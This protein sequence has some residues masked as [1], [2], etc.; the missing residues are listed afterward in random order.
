MAEVRVINPIVSTETRELRV[1]AY[2]RVSSDSDDQQGS[3]LA[4]V[5]YYT[6]FINSH[7]E[8]E[9]VDIYADEGI[10]GTR[11]DK[12]DEFQRLLKDCRKG[13]IDR[14][15]TKLISRFSRNTRDCLETIREL[16][17]LSVEIEFEKEQINTGKITSEMMIGV[18]GSMAQE[19][20]V[21]ISNNMR[22]GYQM[23]MQNGGF[24]TCN[25]PYGYRLESRDLIID[26]AEAKIVRRIF[27]SY[28]TGK[29]VNE[30]AAEL[31]NEQIR[32][33]DGC[34]YWFHSSISYILAN[35]KYIGDALLQKTFST[36]TLP[37]CTVRNTGQKD[38]YYVQ[39]SHPW[40]ICKADFERIKS[41]IK[42]RS[43]YYCHG[44]TARQYPLSKKIQ[45]GKCGHTF[46]RKLGNGGK[47]YWVCGNHYQS[48]ENCSMKQICEGEIYSAFIRLCNKLKHNSRY[49]LT[50]LLDQL[51]ALKSHETKNNVRIGEINKEI[52]ELNEQNLVLNRLRSKGYMDSAVFMEQVNIINQK[53]AHLRGTRRKLL[54]KDEDDQ[55]IT[56][57][58]NLIA[59]MEDGVTTL[60]AFDEVL[61]NSIVDK[62]IVPAQDRL[63]FRLTGG[64]EFTEQLRG[65]NE[66]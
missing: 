26:E 52:A 66:K 41:L 54:D 3:F 30:I 58:R 8:W 38:R 36:D 32:R 4:Q 61:F 57:V 29:G 59:L 43:E 28:L 6:D 31:T 45:C 7:P 53:I 25:P 47:T 44:R 22:L 51:L 39:N 56:D 64:M 42:S 33:K 14:I 46:K 35:E 1:C 11:T 18:L 63:K 34:T 37:F 9:F 20:S 62:I 10:T 40:I 65:V 19:E 5:N 48:K 17:T 50:P 16:K 12:R 13:K 23:R 2:A 15:L 55:M 60:T 24:I 27:Q 21:S 49:I